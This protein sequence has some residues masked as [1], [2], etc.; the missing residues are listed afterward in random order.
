MKTELEEAA[1]N[2]SCKCSKI[3]EPRF[4]ALDGFVEGAKWQAERM[5]SEEEV[6]K[7]L[8]KQQSDYRSAV[9]NT[10]PLNWVLMLR[11]GLNNLKRNKQ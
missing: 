2:Y 11:N 9:R 6:L 3:R 10:S 4:I 5:Y 8:L 7:I 1:E